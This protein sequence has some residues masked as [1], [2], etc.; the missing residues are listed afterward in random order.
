V[1]SPE[2]WRGFEHFEPFLRNILFASLFFDGVFFVT[3][4]NGAYLLSSSK[5]VWQFIQ[6]DILLGFVSSEDGLFKNASR[7]RYLGQDYTTL[8]ITVGLGMGLTVGLA[9]LVP[10]VIVGLAASDSRSRV[11]VEP[12]RSRLR[13]RLNITE[14]QFDPALDKMA[15]WPLKYPGPVELLSFLVVAATCFV[16]YRLTLVLIGP[17]VAASLRRVVKILSAE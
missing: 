1:L 13:M 11:R 10:V 17:V 3:R 16:F 7:L 8:I 5:T 14:Q 2:E 4:L 15:I 12:I 9:F 6:S